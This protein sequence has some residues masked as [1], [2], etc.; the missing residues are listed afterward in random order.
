MDPINLHFPTL[1]QVAAEHP[2]ETFLITV[3][4]LYILFFVVAKPTH[5]YHCR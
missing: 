2:Y 1:L 5:K 3:I 4:A